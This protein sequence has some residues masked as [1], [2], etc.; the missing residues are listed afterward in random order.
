[1]V[2][3][4]WC[5]VGTAR[6]QVIVNQLS[7]TLL[8]PSPPHAQGPC[9]L[10]IPCPY[11]RPVCHF[12]PGHPGVFNKKFF[13]YKLL[14]LICITTLHFVFSLGMTFCTF[15]Q[16]FFA[17][18]CTL[19]SPDNNL[20]NL[21]PALLP[22]HLLFNNIMPITY[23]EGINA[24]LILLGHSPWLLWGKGRCEND[25]QQRFT[26]LLAGPVKFNI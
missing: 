1:M 24:P 5:V 18:K 4:R 26:T 23:F 10:L 11:H 16:H 12:A 9:L 17:K 25:N 15:T 3:T 8:T 19:S 2:E 6:L 21:F 13:C 20:R 7:P 14:A 22:L